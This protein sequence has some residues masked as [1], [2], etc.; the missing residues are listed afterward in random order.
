[1][2][3]P[4]LRWPEPETVD[5]LTITYPADWRRIP[6]P[7]WRSMRMTPEQYGRMRAERVQRERRSPKV[8]ELGARFQRPSG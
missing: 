6:E 3:D 5:R 8:G 1:M 7:I 4:S 2:H